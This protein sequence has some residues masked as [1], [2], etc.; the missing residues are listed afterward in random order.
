MLN[1]W[2]LISMWVVCVCNSVW[3]KSSSQGSLKCLTF[4]GCSQSVLPSLY[5]ALN[6]LVLVVHWS[7]F[8]FETHFHVKHVISHP[9]TLEG[10]WVFL[11]AHEYLYVRHSFMWSSIIHIGTEML[12]IYLSWWAS[13]FVAEGCHSTIVGLSLREIILKIFLFP[14]FFY[15]QT[16]CD[17]PSKMLK[18]YL[19][20]ITLCRLRESS[21]QVP[22]KDNICFNTLRF[23]FCG[24]WWEMTNLSVMHNSFLILNVLISGFKPKLKFYH[25]VVLTWQLCD[26]IQLVRHCYFEFGYL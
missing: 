9:V 4:L 24:R 14:F 13:T 15:W 21:W 17:F 7:M 10:I 5:T 26:E 12:I 8:I 19:C 3:V 16:E 2:E 23:S 20:P 18:R 22:Y 6:T 1:S 25:A 11:E